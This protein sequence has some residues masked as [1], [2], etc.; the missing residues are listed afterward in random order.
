[1]DALIGTRMHSVSDSFRAARRHMSIPT[2]AMVADIANSAGQ[3][4]CR[5]HSG[6]LSQRRIPRSGGNQKKSKTNQIKPKDTRHMPIADFCLGVTCF[7]TSGQHSLSHAL[8]MA[9][10]DMAFYQSDSQ[11]ETLRTLRRGCQPARPDA[12]MRFSVK[13]ASRVLGW[14][15]LSFCKRGRA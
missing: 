8:I 7:T 2:A 13:G 6:S 14:C 15:N 5:R 4:F 11:A 3:T 1:M 12:S 10:S 9:R